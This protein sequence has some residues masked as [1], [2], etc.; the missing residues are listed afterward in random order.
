VGRAGRDGLAGECTM[1]ADLN[2]FTRYRDDFYVGSLG[3]QAKAATLAS[4]DA[5]Q[6]MC[7]SETQCRRHS[8]LTFFEET[9]TFQTC[10]N[11]DN[12]LN[13]LKYGNNQRDFAAPARVVLVALAGLK[14][15]AMS[16][17]EKVTKGVAVEDYR[18]RL[19]G[20]ARGAQEAVKRAREA[21]GADVV[22]DLLRNLLP[23]LV[24]GGYVLQEMQ[25]SQGGQGYAA[26]SYVVYALAA[27][28][29]A[30]LR[31]APCLLRV[32]EAV[33]EAER[34]LEEK[35]QQIMNKLSQ[36]GVDIASIPE[37]ELLQGGGAVMDA[38]G[39]FYAIVER[40][41]LQNPLKAEALLQ[42]KSDII[43]WRAATA[44]R[45][46]MAPAAVLPEHLVCKIAYVCSR[47]P[48]SEKSLSDIGVRVVGTAELAEVTVRWC[49]Q[50]G[51]AQM[52]G[53]GG[54]MVLPSSFKPRAWALAQYT[55][56]KTW[57][58][59]AERFV[60]GESLAAIAINQ[61]VLKGGGQKKPILASTVGNHLLDALSYGK[62]TVDLMRLGMEY[63]PPSS[64]Q[65]AA[66]RG[67][68]AQTGIDVT[69]TA[70]AK[71]DFLRGPCPS[72]A[73]PFNER[74]E[75]D[76]AS[77]SHWQIAL[78]WYT[79]LRRAAYEP[80]FLGAGEG[81]EQKRQRVN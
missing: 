80:Q 62:H 19:Y 78:N 56:A 9:P 59:S 55:P 46:I 2:D 4:L 73:V 57:E 16:V 64:D 71:G 7:M 40:E 67:A 63:P 51:V 43:A 41:R 49:L 23:S 70:W 33:R 25:K 32:P 34:T 54:A 29:D 60:R 38:Y 26:K 11:C 31:G 75:E 15:C 36:A 53:A 58:A 8:L 5:L 18:Y 6:H 10:G 1:F 3:A 22:P 35:R 14:P 79:A 20:G 81:Q 30:V 45:L 50:H 68:E 12:C 13:A 76:K 37:T 61:G 66:L 52:G 48:L 39:H 69:T 65:W 28:G 24:E 77:N 42:L 72:A 74:S 21:P 44:E 47:G 27:G 17:L